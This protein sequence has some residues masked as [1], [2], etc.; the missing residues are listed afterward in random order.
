MSRTPHQFAPHAAGYWLVHAVKSTPGYYE[1][2]MEKADLV[3][4]D[5]HCFESQYLAV[6]G[7]AGSDGVGAV[8]ISE[9]EQ[10]QVSLAISR[11]FVDA[12]TNTN[13]FVKSKGKKFVVVRPTL[14]AP[15]GSMLDTCAKLKSVFFVGSERGIFCDNDRERAWKGE[16]VLLPPVS[17]GYE[18]DVELT[19]LRAFEDRDVL[20]YLRLPCYRHLSRS[21]NSIFLDSVE[22]RLLKSW[23]VLRE[24]FNASESSKVVIEMPEDR[25]GD[26][27]AVDHSA[28]VASRRQ[29]LDLMGRSKYCAVFAPGDRQSSVELGLAVRRGCIPVFLGPPFHAMPMAANSAR[30]AKDELLGIEYAKFALFLHVVDHTKSM[31]AFDDL[32][33][34]DGDLEPDADILKSPVEVPDIIDAIRY[35]QHVPSTVAQ[36]LH[37]G[38]LD[39]RDMFAYGDG[40]KGGNRDGVRG[41]VDVALD[42]MCSYWTKM[43]MEEARKRQ[44]RQEKERQEKERQA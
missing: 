40:D 31:W 24:S 13:A 8:R 44:E 14:G 22:D 7:G 30:G 27:V 5:T 43:K 4:V 26:G 6:T 15:P 42:S 35:V 41:P 17:V 29:S 19:D 16:S 36:G 12:V 9:R 18:M 2:D 11:V 1:P 25:C 23:D 20:M 28:G 3:L 32:S 37:A 10:E 34:S 39:V 38:V 21:P 33:L